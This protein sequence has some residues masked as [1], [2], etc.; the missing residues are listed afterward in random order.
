MSS[1]INDNIYE[2]NEGA[3]FALSIWSDPNN[4]GVTIGFEWLWDMEIVD[5][6]SPVGI[7]EK[8]IDNSINLYPTVAE[9]E[10]TIDITDP[11]V[12]IESVYFYSADGKLIKIEDVSKNKKI[13]IGCL[14]SS[15]YYLVVINTNKGSVKKRL[16]KK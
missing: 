15:S 13:N 9:N 4:T 11:S 12:M 16:I 14:T 1:I 6:E 2:G 5:D 8:E 10:I 7:N 3:Q